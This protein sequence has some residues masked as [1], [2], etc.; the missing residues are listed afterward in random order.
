MNMSAKSYMRWVVCFACVAIHFAEFLQRHKS[1]IECHMQG[2]VL[3][4][5]LYPNLYWDGINK[6][7]RNSL[8]KISVKLLGHRG[9]YWADHLHCIHLKINMLAKYLFIYPSIKPS[10][11]PLISG[12]RWSLSQDAMNKRKE[13]TQDKSPIYGRAH[14]PF[15]VIYKLGTIQTLQL[16]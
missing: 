11:N 14:T 1:L 7:R 15:T 16:I 12:K 4:G 9:I 2:D 10:S 5:D 3:L 8:G 6:I 13:Y